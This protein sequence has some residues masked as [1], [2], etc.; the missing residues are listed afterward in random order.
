MQESMQAAVVG[1]VMRRIE[2]NLEAYD[3]RIT[4]TIEGIVKE[5]NNRFAQS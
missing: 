5:L 2:S 3:T 1:C 4:E